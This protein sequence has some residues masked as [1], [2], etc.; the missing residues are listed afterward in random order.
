[1]SI[2]E[3]P[4]IVLHV[5]DDVPQGNLVPVLLGIEE[6]GVPVQVRRLSELNPLVLARA[7]SAAS[8]LGVGIGA[9]LDYVVVTLDKLDESRPYLAGFLG[10]DVAAD[11][12]VGSNAARIVKRRP[13]RQVAKETAWKR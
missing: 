8:R 5:H 3:R 2:D 9:S 4:A 10:R 1:M 13:L 6:E 11:R 12:V 7:A